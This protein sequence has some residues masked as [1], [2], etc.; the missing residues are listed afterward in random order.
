MPTLLNDEEKMWCMQVC[1]DIPEH[2]DTD[3]DLLKKVI[4]G[5]ETWVFE[6]DQETKRLSLDWMSPQ[7]PQNKKKHG[8]SSRKSN[9]C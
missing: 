8:S 7:S 1:Q 4:A 6:Y 5:D 2:L 9:S 3:P